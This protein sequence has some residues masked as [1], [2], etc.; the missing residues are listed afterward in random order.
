MELINPSFRNFLLFALSQHSLFSSLYFIDTP[1]CLLCRFLTLLISTLWGASGLSPWISLSLALLTCQ[2]WSIA[3]Y[4]QMTPQF[5]SLAHTS[6][7]CI[8]DL[9]FQLLVQCLHLGGSRL[10]VSNQTLISLLHPHHHP[11]TCRKR[12]A[13]LLQGAQAKNLGNLN[14]VLSLTVQPG[15][16]QILSALPSKYIRDLTTL[17]HF[18]CYYIGSSH[19][20]FS[21][22][23][24]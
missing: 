13:G 24:L 20:H 22:G 15:H 16:Q 19:H 3:I 21:P 23:L 12:W 5:I 9:Y 10:G 4:I 1:W 7:P 8:P 18:S 6:L 11:H 2:G 17:F 14:P